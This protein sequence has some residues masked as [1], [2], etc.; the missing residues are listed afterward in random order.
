MIKEL[1]HQQFGY[2][3]ISITITNSNMWYWRSKPRINSPIF[4]FLH[5]G[6]L[7]SQFQK[8]PIPDQLFFKIL[9]TKSDINQNIQELITH[10]GIRNSL[11]KEHK[12]HL[13]IFSDWSWR[14]K[15]FCTAAIDGEG[16]VYALNWRRKAIVG[17]WIVKGLCT[18]LYR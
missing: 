6:S 14:M 9:K 12:T 13:D 18:L 1:Y 16:R 3:V 11:T 15:G 8:D 17:D 7:W 5:K 2:I 10:T 4:Y